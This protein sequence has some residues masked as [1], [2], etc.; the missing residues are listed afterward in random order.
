[1]ANPLLAGSALFIVKVSGRPLARSQ[2]RTDLPGSPA[3]RGALPEL[4]SPEPLSRGRQAPVGFFL[5]WSLGMARLSGLG[6]H[7]WRAGKSMDPSL[8]IMGGKRG[9][10]RVQ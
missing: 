2:P 5:A 4:I 9:L 3:H 1:M 8:T 10:G 7:D 6:R